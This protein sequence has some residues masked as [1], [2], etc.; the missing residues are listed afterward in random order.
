MKT[1]KIHILFSIVCLIFLSCNQANE[2]LSFQGM[3]IDFDEVENTFMDVIKIDSTQFPASIKYEGN[4][5]AA[6]RWTDKLGVHIAFT[7]ETGIFT[8]TKFEHEF[9]ESGDAELFVYHYIL[10]S[11]EAFL[12]W[13]IYDFVHD[14]PVD[15]VAEHVKNAFQITDLDKNGSAE[16]WTMY[17]KVCHG[18]V[19]PSDMKIIMYE[20]NKKYAIRGENKIHFGIN[21]DGTQIYAGGT[22]ETDEAFK[23]GPTVFKKFAEKLW[24]ENCLSK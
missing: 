23:K 5:K 16:I 6:F 17:K 7:T 11:D 24:E 2:R 3:N 1:E 21:E 4:V 20:S 12:K 8:S 18:D 19:S 10:K 15:I 14:C 22:Y 13:K 9:A